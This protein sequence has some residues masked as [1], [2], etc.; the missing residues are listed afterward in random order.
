MPADRGGTPAAAARLPCGFSALPA[1]AWAR[2]QVVY[3]AVGTGL[4]YIKRIKNGEGAGKVVA[5]RRWTWCAA[6]RRSSL[7]TGRS[8]GRSRQTLI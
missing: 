4:C 1:W 6:W 3:L 7:W 2:S 5:C 8:E